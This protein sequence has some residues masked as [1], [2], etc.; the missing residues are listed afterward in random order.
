MNK[1]PAPK[2]VLQNKLRLSKD[3]LVDLDKLMN[4]I[5]EWPVLADLNHVSFIWPLYIGASSDQFDLQLSSYQPD[6]LVGAVD[7]LIDVRW[8]FG[9]DQP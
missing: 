3:K 6:H 9:V 8:N 4:P 7:D 2:V 5:R 1:D